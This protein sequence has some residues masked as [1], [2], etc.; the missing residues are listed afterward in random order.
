MARTPLL[1]V[2][3]HGNQARIAHS[4]VVA[5][6]LVDLAPPLAAGLL[7]RQIDVLKGLVDLR[8]GAGGDAAVERVPT[9]CVVPSRAL[10]TYLLLSR[11]GA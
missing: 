3:D 1:Q 10:V 9:A 8:V 2:P 4:H 7:E 6:D 5:A 11:C